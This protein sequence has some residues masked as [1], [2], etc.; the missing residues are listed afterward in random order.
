MVGDTFGG[1]ERLLQRVAQWM[2]ECNAQAI[3]CNTDEVA[4]ITRA[5]AAEG[6]A[7]PERAKA[8]LQPLRVLLDKYR[9]SEE[10]MTPVHAA[11]LKSYAPQLKGPLPRSPSM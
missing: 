4:I 11:L 6:E 5:F 1:D 2:L 8:T 3:K 10:H 9:P 7:S